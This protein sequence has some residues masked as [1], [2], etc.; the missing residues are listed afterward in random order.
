MRVIGSEGTLTLDAFKQKID[1][2]NNKDLKASWA[3]WGS[4][5]DLGLVQSFIDA[6]ENNTPVPITGEDGLRAMEVA[7]GAY[8]S[9]KKAQPVALPL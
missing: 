9:A 4:N 3:Y 2:Y 1:V 7:L 8:L 5:M 6:V